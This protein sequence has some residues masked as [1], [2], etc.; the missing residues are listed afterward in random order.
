MEPDRRVLCIVVK[1]VFRL[2]WQD[3]SQAV[4][5]MALATRTLIVF[6]S[7]LGSVPSAILLRMMRANVVDTGFAHSLTKTSSCGPRIA[8]GSIYRFSR[9]RSRESLP[10]VDSAPRPACHS[11]RARRSRIGGAS[12]S[13]SLADVSN[14]T[15]SALWHSTVACCPGTCY[16]GN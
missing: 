15:T 1:L 16:P 7:W 3:G 11:L 12:V 8:N 6:G 5:R 9:Y 2:G 4:H 14:A 10:V 13:A